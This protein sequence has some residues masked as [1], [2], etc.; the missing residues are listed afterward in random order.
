MWQDEAEH[1]IR[2]HQSVYT[3]V[4]MLQMG[5]LW[6]I[7][8]ALA[9]WENPPVQ[10]QVRK[11]NRKRKRS[12]RQPDPESVRF[13]LYRTGITIT[14]FAVGVGPSF[15]TVFHSDGPVWDAIAGLGVGLAPWAMTD[16]AS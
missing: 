15:S 8:V 11:Q 13:V 16:L 6:Q 7:E 12:P 9:A 4:R 5:I 1:Y 14:R 2:E 3:V 10:P